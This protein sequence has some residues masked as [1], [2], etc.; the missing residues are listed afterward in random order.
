MF[1]ELIDKDALEIFKSNLK[2]YVS[3]A[4]LNSIDKDNTNTR[5]NLNKIS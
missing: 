5:N 1:L 2:K 4:T 3:L